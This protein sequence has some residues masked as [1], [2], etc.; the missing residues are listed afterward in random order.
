MN[1]LISKISKT[2]SRSS[3]RESDKDKWHCVQDITV[4]CFFNCNI[5]CTK[6]TIEEKHKARSIIELKNNKGTSHFNMN[7]Q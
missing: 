1:Y 3:Q 7:K 4:K 5:L 6:A 2:T